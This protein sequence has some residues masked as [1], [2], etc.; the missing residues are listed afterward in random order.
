MKTAIYGILFCVLATQ[1]APA[2]PP[3]QKKST[4]APPATT[5]AQ[6]G[7]ATWMGL[8]FGMTKDQVKAALK[9]KNIDLKIADTRNNE[10]QATGFLGALD[11]VATLGF[12]SPNSTGLQVIVLKFNP[13]DEVTT[14]TRGCDAET[15]TVDAGLEK[16]VRARMIAD[17]YLERYGKPF[18]SD[19]DFPVGSAATDWDSPWMRRLHAQSGWT[20]MV[21]WVWRDGGQVV[22]FDG[23]LI[24]RSLEITVM[25]SPDAHHDF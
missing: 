14:A 7:T 8:T 1:L 19:G 3:P 17:Q 6:T 4:A 11:G 20:S 9:A 21:R 18:H 23:F 15:V 12:D 13:Q 2:A 24:C 16:L 25:Y 22:Q 5:T 10:L